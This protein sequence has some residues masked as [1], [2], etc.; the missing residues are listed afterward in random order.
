MAAFKVRLEDGSEMGPL[1]MEMLRS[2]YQQGLVTADRRSGARTASSGCR[3]STPWTSRL[4]PGG[5]DEGAR[6]RGGRRDRRVL[7]DPQRWRIFLASVLF[8]LVAAG[9]G[10]FFMFPDRWIPSLKEAPWRRSR[11]ASS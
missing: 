11:S 5:R 6:G 9:A 1:D 2:W 7:D 4:G 3:S 8:F 10:Y